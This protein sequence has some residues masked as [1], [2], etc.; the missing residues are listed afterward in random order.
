MT[1]YNTFNGNEFNGSW[2]MKV[3]I[4]WQKTMTH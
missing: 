4:N 3:K 1:E 2:V